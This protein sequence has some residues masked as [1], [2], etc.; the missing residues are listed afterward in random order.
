MFRGKVHVE[1]FGDDFLGE[2]SNGAKILGQKLEGI[3]ALRTP[4]SS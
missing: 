4:R 2:N 1:V 3:V